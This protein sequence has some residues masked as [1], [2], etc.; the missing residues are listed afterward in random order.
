M[1]TA[2]YKMPPRVRAEVQRILDRA[3]QRLLA[4][5]RFDVLTPAPKADAGAGKAEA[6]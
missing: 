2:D 4:E 5:G 6:S 1:A 3:A